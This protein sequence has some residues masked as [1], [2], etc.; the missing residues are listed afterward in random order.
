[1]SLIEKLT[2]AVSKCAVKSCK[3]MPWIEKVPVAF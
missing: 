1:M 2:L 3:V